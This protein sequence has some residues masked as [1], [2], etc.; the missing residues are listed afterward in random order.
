MGAVLPI[1]FTVCIST[2]YGLRFLQLGFVTNSL[3]ADFLF[4]LT[5]VAYKGVRHVDGSSVLGLR[6]GSPGTSG[7]SRVQTLS[8]LLQRGW[9]L[10]WCCVGLLVV[11]L[12]QFT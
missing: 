11:Y 4:Y 9:D 7:C 1:C 2:Y 6:V 12:I 5:T 8:T 3:L 10:V